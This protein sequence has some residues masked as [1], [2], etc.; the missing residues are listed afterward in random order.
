MI[1]TRFVI[2]TGMSGAGKTEAIRAFEDLGYF[3]I[4][5]LPAT[6]IPKF[7]ELCAQSEGKINKIALVIDVRSGEFFDSAVEALGNLEEMGTNYEILFLEASTE[8]LVRRYKETR[9]R[10]PLASLGGI[11]DGIKIERKRLDELRGKATK[12]IDTSALSSRELRARIVELFGQEGGAHRIP[13]VVVSFGF[14]YGVPMDA[15]LV[16]DVRFLPNPHYVESLRPLTGDDEPVREYVLKWPVTH[17]FTQKL[18]DFMAFLVPLYVKEGKTQLIIA[19]GC[20]GG[21]HRSV[22]LATSLGEF[23][24]EKGY[25]ASIE[26][27]DVNRD[28]RGD[29]TT[30]GAENE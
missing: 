19:I 6:L 7:A 3:C 20:T 13:V 27:R 24:R 12:I 8:V 2:I 5:N 17:K 15:D 23:L 1:N 9:R 18:F 26:H 25:S 14:K 29:K 11:V 4:D 10:H 21:R 22:T 28:T 30:L 16:F